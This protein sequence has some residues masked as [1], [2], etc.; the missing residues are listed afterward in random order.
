LILNKDCTI[1]QYPITPYINPIFMIFLFKYKFFLLMS[2]LTSFLLLF[3]GGFNKIRVKINTDKVIRNI[4][5]HIIH[6][7][8]SMYIFVKNVT[9]IP[10]KNKPIPELPFIIPITNPLLVGNHLVIMEIKGVKTNAVPI[11]NKNI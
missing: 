11:P 5:I 10:T 6:Q 4:T 2:T 7:P 9:N 8:C 3:E 1:K